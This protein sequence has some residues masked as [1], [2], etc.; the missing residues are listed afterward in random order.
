MTIELFMGVG[1]GLIG[2]VASGL[3]G[4]SPGG[5]LVP[6]A[7]LVLGC[8]QHV[9]QGISLIAQI[10]PTG[11]SGIRRYRERGS[12]T[13]IRWLVFLAIGFLA[14][15]VGG[16]LFAGRISS[17][18][19]N[20]SYVGYLSLLVA[21]L[22]FRRQTVPTEGAGPAK[23]ADDLPWT[24]LLAVGTVAGVSSGFMGI[25]GGLAITVG[26]TGI[27]KVPQHQAQAVG[28]VLALVPLTAPAGWIYWRQGWPLPWVAIAG[29]IM[30]LW[31]GADL[32]ARLANRI[33]NTTLRRLLIGLVS[34]FAIYMAYQAL[35]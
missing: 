30:G 22:I 12:R 21:L 33:S 4:V 9:A 35:R 25:G 13:P 27:L 23:A 15:G 10:P 34:V 24:A 28:L 6:I 1:A 31:A 2:G 5:I 20:W 17:T 11:V 3:L 8:E 7:I 29:V 14:G 16:A 19:L 32:G 26:L 18:A